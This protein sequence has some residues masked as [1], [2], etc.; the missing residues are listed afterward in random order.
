[1][2]SVGNKLEHHLDDKYY[3]KHQIRPVQNFLQPRI[4]IQVDVLEAESNA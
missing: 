2:K 3:A 1:M 4:F